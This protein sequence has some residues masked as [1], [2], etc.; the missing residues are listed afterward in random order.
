MTDG[1]LVAIRPSTGE[2]LAM[3]GSADFNNET[4]AGQINMALIP[5]QPGSSIKPLTYTAAFEKGWTPA[6]L[7]W[8]VPSEFAPSDDKFDT[9]PP[10]KP[11]NYDNK[12]HGPVL[13]RS[14][15]ANSF[16]VPAVKTMQYVGIYDNPDTPQQ[17]GFLAFAQRMGVTSLT[18]P[19]YGLSLGL[20]GGE[21]PLIE[22]TAAY[23]IF[24]TGGQKIPLTA[25]LRIEDY[26]GNVVYEFSPSAGDQVIR[27]EHA[28]LITSI[29]SDNQARTPMFGSNSV[30]N[31]PFQVAA[32]TGT[33]NDF[34]DNWTLGYTPDLAVGVWV[35]NAD[36]TPMVNSSGL[37][38]AAPIWSQF[39]QAAE[40]YI[41]N[42]NPTN[43]TRP[44]GI[45]E[46]SICT[47]SGARPSLDCPKQKSEL[48]AYD[49]PPLSADEDLWKEIKID[50]WTG[51][52]SSSACSEYTAD[53][54]VANIKDES[55]KKWILETTDGQN[56]AAEMGFDDPIYF[57]PERECR[58]DDSHPNIVF[59]SPDKNQVISTNPLDIYAI[60][61]A[62]SRFNDYRLQY[63]LGNSPNSWKTLISKQKSQHT[64]AEKIY[65]WDLTGI[66]PGTVTLRIYMTSKDGHF[67]Q[68][69]LT[70]NVQVPTLTPT[71]TTTL[72]PTET[73]TPTLPPTETPTETPTPSLTST[74]TETPTATETPTP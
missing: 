54:K 2:I 34:R 52:R 64:S 27:P 49:Q 37:T 58:S 71:P 39:M 4:I 55:A 17:E 3:V 48:F 40:M 46:Y 69:R 61:S 62:T 11:V 15:L 12:F 19:Y 44:A 32:K 13:V 36:Y 35:G 65:T 38:G 66:R 22:M 73:P 72:V 41:S 14:A 16:N 68:K 29:L 10:Y 57:L 5:R 43:F 18:Q 25:I 20:G 45:V 21:I 60:I 9:N 23:S 28:Y 42:N 67:A 53:V 47:S 56:W 6:T 30:L 26:S 7:I 63:G 1:A 74:M 8:D 70:I 24:A 59:A 51:L 31:L 50:T 33:T